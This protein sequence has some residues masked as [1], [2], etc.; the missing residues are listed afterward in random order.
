[1]GGKNLDLGHLEGS[2]VM[3]CGGTVGGGLCAFLFGFGRS[4]DTMEH[5]GCEG[6]SS[7]VM[8]GK[9]GLAQVGGK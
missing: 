6:S 2:P 7:T 9:G 8:A 4:G 3:R 5:R 1:V